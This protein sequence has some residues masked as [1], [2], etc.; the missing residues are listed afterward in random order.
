MNVFS[1]STYKEFLHSYIS[2]HKQKGMVS[3]VA[4]QCGCDRTYLSQVLNGKADLKPDHMIQFCDHLGLSD[5]ESRYLL[6]VLLRDRS[7]AIEARKSLQSKIDKLKQEALALTAKIKSKEKTEEIDEASRSQYYSHW[8]YCA[9]HILTSIPE[10]QTAPAL[11]TK[12]SI[13]LEVIQRILRELLEMKAIKRDKDK[14][15]H[16]SADIYLPRQHP[17]SYAHH[18][19]WRMK[20]VERSLHE[21]DVH[22]TT[23]FTI[24][25][26]DVDPLRNAIL[27]LIDEQRRKV[28]ASGTEIGY[29]FCC[30]FFPV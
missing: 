5:L 29:A 23:F 28:Q 14:Y 3:Q 19:N 2:D 8:S 27:K 20:A 13:P 11:A 1:F 18:L 25:K 17:Q 22:Y 12:L 15:I 7:S 4:A 21:Q 16:S 24:S 10:F 26:E 30:D 6:L 9:I